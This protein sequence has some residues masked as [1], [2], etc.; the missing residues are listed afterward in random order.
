MGYVPVIH[1]IRFITDDVSY[2]T[3]WLRVFSMFCHFSTPSVVTLSYQMTFEL[4]EALCI[5]VVTSDN[6]MCSLSSNMGCNNNN[7][8][9]NM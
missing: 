9:I 7:I 4:E 5:P 8:N 2:Y 3:H 6:S 1:P